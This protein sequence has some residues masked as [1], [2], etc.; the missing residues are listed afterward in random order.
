LGVFWGGSGS[1]GERVVQAE[2]HAELQGNRLT[3][4]VSDIT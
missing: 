2:K 3:K 4:R 1:V